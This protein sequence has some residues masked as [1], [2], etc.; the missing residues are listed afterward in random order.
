MIT[1]TEEDPTTHTGIAAGSLWF[2]IQQAFGSWFL[3]S[4]LPVPLDLQKGAYETIQ[5]AKDDAELILAACVQ[6][7]QA[8]QSPQTEV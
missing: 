6:V 7:V 5:E 2:K 4:A 1:W 8:A 3:A